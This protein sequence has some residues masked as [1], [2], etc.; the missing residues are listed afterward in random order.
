[1]FFWE[2]KI[3]W[4]H[5]GHFFELFTFFYFCFK[6]CSFPVIII[7]ESLNIWCS[8]LI[9]FKSFHNLV[10]LLYHIENIFRMYFSFFV[11]ST[12]ENLYMICCDSKLLYDIWNKGKREGIP[13]NP[14]YH[15]YLLHRHSDISQEIT[16]ES[17]PLHIDRSRT[18]TRNLW[19]PSASR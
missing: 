4:A 14:H 19:F 18:R 9:F 8:L 2:N 12:W 6:I 13:L 17:S 11:L 10:W 1:M 3:L 16:T 15:F 7:Y 5:F